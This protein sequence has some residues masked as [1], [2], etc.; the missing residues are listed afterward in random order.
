MQQGI[1][2]VGDP[3]EFALKMI[4]EC[5]DVLFDQA[6]VM[7]HSINREGDLVKV[8]QRWLRTLGYEIDDT[9]GRLSVDFLTDESRVQAN[10]DTLPLF[11][12]TGSARG[13]GYSMI[14]NS[15]QVLDVLLDAEMVDESRRAVSTL[16]TLRMPNDAGQRG[17]ALATLKMLQNLGLLEHR[18]DELHASGQL[19]ELATYPESLGLGSEVTEAL[20]PSLNSV[21][22]EVS[23][24]LR[25]LA[26]LKANEI[27]AMVNLQANYLLLADTIQIAMRQIQGG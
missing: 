21:A 19:K 1:M 5:Y 18:L 23:S 17:E 12:E 14:Q 22:Q 27:H 20:L 13:V 9:V 6:P 15:G 2:P 4:T 7:M 24:D 26:L 8:N 25:N 3:I 11:W 16:A 10:R